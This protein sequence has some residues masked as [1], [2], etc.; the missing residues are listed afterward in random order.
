MVHQ[1]M[2]LLC[3]ALLAPQLC[4]GIRINDA[5]TDLIK[6]T[7][8]GLKEVS[9]AA[10]AAVPAEGA[11]AEG[12]D[13][14]SEIDQRCDQAVSGSQARASAWRQYRKCKC[15]EENHVVTCEGQNKCMDTGRFFRPTFE[16]RCQC[17][18]D[19]CEANCGVVTG[20]IH[21]KSSWRRWEEKCKCPVNLR[22][23]GSGLRCKAEAAK[24][25]RKYNSNLLKGKG[26]ECITDAEANATLMETT[27]R[28]PTEGKVDPGGAVGTRL[29]GASVAAMGLLAAVFL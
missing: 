16:W 9:E 27:P 10:A 22:V 15:K 3:T 5:D 13:G 14:M 12:E 18:V 19:P 23:G 1:R 28:P 25:T 11:V 8:N 6:H 26:C 4:V 29:S 21:R 2:Q 17:R 24:G 7:L 20:G